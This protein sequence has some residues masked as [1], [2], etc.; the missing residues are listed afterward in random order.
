MAFEVT[1]DVEDGQTVALLIDNAATPSTV[2][3]AATLTAATGGASSVSLAWNAP[4]SDGGTPITAYRVYRGT[5]SGG[6]TLLTTIASVDPMYVEFDVPERALLRYRQHF[7]KGP[8]Q[9]GADPTVLPARAAETFVALRRLG[10][11]VELV[12]YEGEGHHPGSWS[13]ANATDYWR[14]IFDWFDKYVIR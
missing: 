4:V 13:V 7:R 14:R 5:T 8:N 3:G 9:G 2:P 10:R 11:P 6:E 1:T 12:R